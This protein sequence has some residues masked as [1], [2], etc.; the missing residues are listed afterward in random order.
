MGESRSEPEFE[1]LAGDEFSV[2]LSV[3][4]KFSDRAKKDNERKGERRS[5]V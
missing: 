2:D 5:W 4:V 1:S 3:T